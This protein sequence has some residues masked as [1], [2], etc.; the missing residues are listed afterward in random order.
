MILKEFIH[1]IQNKLGISLYE[2]L[3]IYEKRRIDER[4]TLGENGLKNESHVTIIHG[5]RY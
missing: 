2:L 1:E 4:L 5:F 3:F